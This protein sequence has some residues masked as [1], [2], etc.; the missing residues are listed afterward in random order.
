MKNNKNQSSLKRENK[1]RNVASAEASAQGESTPGTKCTIDESAK[2]PISIDS[3]Y[4]EQIIEY[5]TGSRKCLTPKQRSERLN[6]EN[7]FV[8]FPADAECS[9]EISGHWLSTRFCGGDA[10]VL[11]H[12]S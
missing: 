2:K 11:Q 6:D 1:S 5:I 8:L 10:C 7:I 9:T 4:Q 3:K 12:W